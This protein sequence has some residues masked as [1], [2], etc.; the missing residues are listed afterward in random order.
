VNPSPP[1]APRPARPGFSLVEL[2]VVIAVIAT[3]AGLLL[4]ALSHSIA[5]ARQFRC[6]VSLR[7]VG[8]DFGVFADD[9][10]HGDRGHD[11]SMAPRFRLETF[12]ES[13]YGVDEFWR[14]GDKPSHTLP[15]EADN[16]P[17]RCA[18]VGGMLTLRR[19][20][21]CRAGAVG[22]AE[23]VSFTFNGRLD[24]A[25]V[26]GGD[27]SRWMQVTLTDGVVFRPMLPLAWDV[28][29]AEAGRR[30]VSP[31]FSA[32]GLEEARGPFAGDALWFP[33]LRHAGAANV[34]FTDQHVESSRDPAGET[35]WAWSF[36]PR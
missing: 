10:L 15:D 3:I 22:P 16:D 36:L 2:L 29:G 32:P 26:R 35:G 9:T 25:P 21:P 23:S 1:P 12:Q 17:M 31:V 4:P 14:W 7:S 13:E 11:A 24:R 8:F 30:G 28:D 34:L 27:G 33:S 5:L 6:Q 20:A 19:G 18:E